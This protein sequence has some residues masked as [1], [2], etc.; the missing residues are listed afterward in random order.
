MTH[1]WWRYARD[2]FTCDQGLLL[3]VGIHRRALRTV[4]VGLV[5]GYEQALFMWVFNRAIPPYL[6]T[7]RLNSSPKSLV[8][9]RFPHKL[10]EGHA[11]GRGAEERDLLLTCFLTPLWPI[12]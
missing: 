9:N 4:N 8:L 11:E 2:E 6:R 12:P 1:L 5:M 10:P 7:P 3:S